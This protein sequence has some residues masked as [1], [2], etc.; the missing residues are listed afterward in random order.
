MVKSKPTKSKADLK[1]GKKRAT[2]E[3]NPPKKRVITKDKAKVTK[4]PSR[5][6][7]AEFWNGFAPNYMK[8]EKNNFQGA[9]TAFLMAGVD[10]PG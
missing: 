10:K 3:S 7:T 1:S 8:V 6:A 5:D 9:L 2:K 4:A